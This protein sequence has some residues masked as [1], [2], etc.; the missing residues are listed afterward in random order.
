MTEVPIDLDLTQW[1]DFREDQGAPN[2]YQTGLTNLIRSL[3]KSP[4]PPKLPP[5][6]RRPSPL[7]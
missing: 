4:T 6:H 1:M 2:T 3:A 5:Y 7:H